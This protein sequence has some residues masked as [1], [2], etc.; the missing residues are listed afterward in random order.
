MYTKRLNLGVDSVCICIS[1]S[2]M[3]Q[4]YPSDLEAIGRQIYQICEGRS[5]G[6][7]KGRIK[8]FERKQRHPIFVYIC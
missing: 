2:I 4:L 1:K 8:I 5:P 3:S 7:I 6:I